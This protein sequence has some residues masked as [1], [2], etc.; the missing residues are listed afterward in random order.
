MAVYSKTIEE[1]RKNKKLNL[2]DFKIKMNEL[3]KE[4]GSTMEDFKVKLEGK[5]LTYSNSSKKRIQYFLSTL[6]YY[7]NDYICNNTSKVLM[8]PTKTILNDTNIWIEHIYSQEAR[9]DYKNDYM[10]NVVNKIG[11]LTLLQ[12]SNNRKLGNKSFNEKKSGK[13]YGYDKEKISIT[14]ILKVYNKW[15]KDE[16][17]IRREMYL[18]MASKIFTL[19]GE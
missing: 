10:D 13:D 3:L 8:N 7:Y 4:Q 19:D 17:K 18:D 15:E 2:S 12:D 16:Y 14:N 6:E 9:V 11:N 5:K 1:I